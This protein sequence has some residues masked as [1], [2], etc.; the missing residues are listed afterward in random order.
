MK[1][2][3]LGSSP[4]AGAIGML[5]ESINTYSEHKSEVFVKKLF[6]GVGNF[7]IDYNGIL[8]ARDLNAHIKEADII[9]VHNSHPYEWRINGKPHLIQLH[10][11]PKLKGGIAKDSPNNCCT[12][13][14]KHALLYKKL[15]YVP[16]LVPLNKKVYTYK[17]PRNKR[18]VYL[19]YSPTSKTK[20]L[21]YHETCRGKGYSETI[22]VLNRLYI[23]FGNR[24]R[25]GIFFNKDKV[26]VLKAKRTSDIVI[27]ECVTGGYHLSGLEG[28]AMGN[29]VVGYLMPKVIDLITE[30]SGCHSDELPWINTKQ[31]FLFQ[32]LKALINLKLNN[33][34]KFDELR[35]KSVDW[36]YKYW[37][38]RN[39]LKHYFSLYERILENGS[40]ISE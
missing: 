24:I 8:K 11:E 3:Q 25:L 6:T 20:F 19:V 37:H 27:D 14:Q 12:L 33:P 30:M 40:L 16:N 10:S 32:R 9:H 13:A 36:V 26:E 34:Q 21:D 28:L 35:Q 23:E 1:I 4:C 17:E 7:G 31:E 15:P 38:P 39:L 2:L 29:V 5:S 22:D 18:Q